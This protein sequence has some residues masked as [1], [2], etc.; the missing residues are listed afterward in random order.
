MLRKAK[1]YPSRALPQVLLEIAED[2]TLEVKLVKVLDYSEKQLR[3]KKIC[4]IK[5][6]WR[7]SQIEEVT[8][9]RESEMRRKYPE[10]FINTGKNLISRTKLL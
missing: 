2:L 5:V 10:L 6:L 8:W 9:E 1:V 3:N 4:M 7:S